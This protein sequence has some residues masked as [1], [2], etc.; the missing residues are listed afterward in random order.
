MSHTIVVVDDDSITLDI[1]VATLEAQFDATVYS[2]TDSRMAKRFFQEHREDSLSL[3]ISD[4]LMPRYSGMELLA[5]IR[6]QKIAT[7]VLLVSAEGTRENAVEAK[8]FGASGFVVKPFKRSDF[9]AKVSTY[10]N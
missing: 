6:Q 9:I 8:K 7:P 1:M 2:F 10:L 4:V 3:I 5:F